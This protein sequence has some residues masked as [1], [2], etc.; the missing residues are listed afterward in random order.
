M[1]LINDLLQ[2]QMHEYGRNEGSN[3]FKFVILI[4]SF[5]FRQSRNT[6]K[7]LVQYPPRG[8]SRTIFDKLFTSYF[9]SYFIG[10]V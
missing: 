2:I 5:H 4:L 9:L 3:V 10:S 6:N 7:F 1:V 8:R